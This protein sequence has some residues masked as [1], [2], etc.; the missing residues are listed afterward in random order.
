MFSIQLTASTPNENRLSRLLRDVETVLGE[1]SKQCCARG[2]GYC[3]GLLRRDAFGQR[4]A[5]ALI[6]ES[7]LAVATQSLDLACS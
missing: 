7:V 6:C 1:E 3:S 2:E 4:E 5:N